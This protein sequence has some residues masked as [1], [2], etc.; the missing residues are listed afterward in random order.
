M[1]HRP[2]ISTT[3]LAL[4][5]AAS[6]LCVSPASAQTTSPD[7]LFGKPRGS[8]GLRSGWVFA[9][10]RSDLFTFVQDQLT[11]ARK[12]F[13]APA[14]GFDV[15]LTITPRASVVAGFDFSKTSKDSE[16]RNFVD[17]RRLPINQTTSLRE[18]Y[19][20]GSFK[21]ALTPR[22]REISRRAWIP[23]AVTPYVGA[24]GGVLSYQFLQFG[25]FIDVEDF[26][27]F[28]ETYRSSGLAPAG[29]VFGG[30]DVRVWKRLYM[31]GEGRY[32][33]SKATLD[34]DFSGF[35]PIDLAGF[36]LSGGVHYMF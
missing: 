23:A 3:A 27:V 19:F 35:D 33:W 13:N 5:L 18:M 21:F 32:L 16:Y 24:G 2:S 17:N 34:R 9:S 7:F 20:S 12:D 26:D 29:H 22:G 14:V 8:V 6:G 28:P 11:V 1:R 25:D 4:A 10:A 36:K 31:S 15:D 30:V